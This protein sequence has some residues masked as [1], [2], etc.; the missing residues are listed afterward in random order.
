M[1][2]ST[3]DGSHP[4]TRVFRLRKLLGLTQEGLA[5]RAGLRRVEVSKVESGANQAR[6]FAM[7]SALARGFGVSIEQMAE[8]L[9]G[10]VDAD[11]LLPLC[12]PP[13][14]AEPAASSE[15]EAPA[16]HEPATEAP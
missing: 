5:A 7:R 1:A 13:A 10:E 6:S 12:A 4:G 11:S 9:D 8:L 2:D 3:G 14:H 16:P 15:Q